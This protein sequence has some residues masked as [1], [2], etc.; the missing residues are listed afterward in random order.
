MHSGHKETSEVSI[1]VFITEIHAA[2][3]KDAKLPK[4]ILNTDKLNLK[5]CLILIVTLFTVNEQI[6]Y[7]VSALCLSNT[8]TSVGLR[9]GVANFDCVI[10]TDMVKRAQ[11]LHSLTYVESNMSIAVS[12]NGCN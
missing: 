2:C 4:T 3:S 7:T 1:I 6:S 8:L 9:I 11:R 12:K 5:K 10:C